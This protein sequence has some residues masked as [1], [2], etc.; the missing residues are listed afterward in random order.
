MVSKLQ[1]TIKLHINV[2]FVKMMKSTEYLTRKIQYI[3][4]HKFNNFSF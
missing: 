2:K 1:R 4:L 3:S